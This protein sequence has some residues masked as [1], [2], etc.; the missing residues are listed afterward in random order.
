MTIN[1]ANTDPSANEDETLKKNNR[2][3]KKTIEISE[4]AILKEPYLIKFI[5]T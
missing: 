3:G 5:L 4:I 1:A 2:L